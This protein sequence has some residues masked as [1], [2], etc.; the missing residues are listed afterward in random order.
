VVRFLSLQPDVV[1]A[2][3]LLA[4]PPP[5]A[6][7][8]DPVSGLAIAPG[9]FIGVAADDLAQADALADRLGRYGPEPADPEPGGPVPAAAE[10]GGPAGPGGG[11]PAELG[12]VR[13][14][15]LPVATVR[16]RILVARGDA[17]LFAGPFADVLDGGDYGEAARGRH[18]PAGSRDAA[19]AAALHVASAE[20]VLDAVPGGR[21]GYLPARG[22][23]LSGG[24]AQ[25]VRLARALLADPEVLVLIEP[26]S[27][28][29]AH[30]EARIAGRLRAARQGRATVV[31]TTSPLLLD[32]ADR[33]AYLRD[34]RVAAT[35]SHRDLLSSTPEYADT[36]TRG[37][38]R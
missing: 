19:L 38:D 14:R 10:P 24:Q 11:R 13:L 8:H 29:D 18:R 6:V 5:G 34:G 31:I 35:G 21:H 16:R 27:A 20:D 9:E 36:V 3:R 22:R 1:D 32:A 17:Q 15:D 4:E 12:G 30:T 33:V 37:E 7:L 26:T 23:T 28:V 25:R 2:G